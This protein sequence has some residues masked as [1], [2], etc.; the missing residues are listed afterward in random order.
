M[1]SA[2]PTA[3]RFCSLV[4]GAVGLQRRSRRVTGGREE[5]GKRETRD[6][7]IVTAGAALSAAE[8]DRIA[9]K[10]KQTSSVELLVFLCD[11]I[12]F[13]RAERG[14]SGTRRHASPLFPPLLPFS[15]SSM[16]RKQAP[17]AA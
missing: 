6:D 3:G 12:E 15:F 11:S 1:S 9:Q 7:P 2:Q 4:S 10:H 13:G 5:G 17:E 14:P 16:T 8:L